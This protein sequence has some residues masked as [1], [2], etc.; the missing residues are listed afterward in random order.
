MAHSSSLGD[1]SYFLNK[2]IIFY[3]EEVKHDLKIFLKNN[4]INYKL[5]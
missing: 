2:N 1:N 5:N 4:I 3:L